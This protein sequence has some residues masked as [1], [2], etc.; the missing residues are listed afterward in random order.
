MAAEWTRETVKYDLFDGYTIEKVSGKKFLKCLI[1][2][3]Q[4]SIKLYKV[5]QEDK[6]TRKL[7]LFI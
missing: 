2:S 7:Y 1:I 3:E 5:R 4:Q 6:I